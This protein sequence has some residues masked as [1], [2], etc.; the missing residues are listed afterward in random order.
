MASPPSGVFMEKNSLRMAGQHIGEGT[1]VGGAAR[2]IQMARKRRRLA[3]ILDLGGQ[4]LVEAR[5]DLVGDAVQGCRALVRRQTRPGTFQRAPC[6]AHGVVDIGFGRLIHQGVDLA[7][8]GIDV[9][10]GIAVRRSGH[11]RRR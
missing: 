2:D 9:F 11:R 1:K 6:R 8:R 5:L 4:E 3:G 10:D 7:G